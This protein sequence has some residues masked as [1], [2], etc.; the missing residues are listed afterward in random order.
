MRVSMVAEGVATLGD[1]AC[2]RGKLT[3][4]RADHKKCR[5]NLMR[6]KQI[7]KRRGRGRVGT[8]V[9]RERDGIRAARAPDGRAEQLG[10]RNARCPRIGPGRATSS[11]RQ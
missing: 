9:E 6:V 1:F 4:A 8:I 2:E 11:S 7:Q 3:D 5:A 10:R